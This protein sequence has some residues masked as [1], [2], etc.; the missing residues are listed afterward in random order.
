MTPDTKDWTWV[1]DS[2]C[3][4]CG[5]EAGELH[6]EDIGTRLL[7]AARTLKDRLADADA[8]TRPAPG[9]WSPLEY[10]CHTRDAC[11]IFE[12]RLQE[13]LAT[14]HPSFTNWDQDATAD[15]E[16]YGSQDPVVV[17]GQLWEAAQ[18]AASRFNGVNENQ[19]DRTGSR[20]DGATFSIVSLGQYFVHD[21]VHHV[22]DVTGE[23]QE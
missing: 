15:A 12:Q 18:V 21:L 2:A 16:A 7:L 8:R 13:M 22:W 6:R 19:W 11:E 14:E 4:E 17:A 1:L 9:V 23:P 20:S 3:P 10:A 5:F